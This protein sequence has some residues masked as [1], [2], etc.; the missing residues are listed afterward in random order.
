MK[1]L[2]ALT[3]LTLSMYSADTAGTW[4]GTMRVTAT[5]EKPVDVAAVLVLE[6]SA[7]G[8][9]GT[10][11]PAGKAPETIR[12]AKLDGD[13]LSFE[14]TSTPAVKFEGQIAAGTLKA[15]A[16]FKAQ[17]E[18]QVTIALDLKRGQ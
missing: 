8:I 13:K 1:L 11:T 17:G 15:A 7:S 6:E 3:L 10:F 5:G 16:A 2:L 18:R 14:I 12:N 9:T 4:S